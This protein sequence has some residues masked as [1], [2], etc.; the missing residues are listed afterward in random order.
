VDF[1][2]PLETK[3]TQARSS[4]PAIADQP[5]TRGGTESLTNSMGSETTQNSRLA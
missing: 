3:A 1:E 4:T 2:I 5:K